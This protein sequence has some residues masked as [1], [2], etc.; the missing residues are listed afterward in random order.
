MSPDQ[1][2]AVDKLDF[3]YMG[4]A[5]FTIVA[6]VASFDLLPTWMFINSASL[7]A[8]TSMINV[9][10]PGNANHLLV[11]WIDLFRFNWWDVN[12]KMQERVGI[13]ELQTK[14]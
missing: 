4:T 3:I 8:H 12:E 9:D 7:L 13:P 14:D 5:L 1:A 6:M 2:G 11:K 10:F